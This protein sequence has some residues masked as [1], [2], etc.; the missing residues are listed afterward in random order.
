MGVRASVKLVSRYVPT[1][2][3][4]L[5]TE[6]FDF[7]LSPNPKMT[8][9]Q[10]SVDVSAVASGGPSTKAMPWVAPISPKIRPRRSAVNT[11]PITALATGAMPPAPMP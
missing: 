3:A 1:E 6:S 11:S 4:G 7:L 9:C 8:I 2:A 5:V 10:P